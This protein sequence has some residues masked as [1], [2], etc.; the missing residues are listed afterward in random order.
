MQVGDQVVAIGN[1]LNLGDT[2]TVTTGIV[3][4]KGRTHR[5]RTE[6][7][8]DLIQTD[9]AINPGNSGGP[10]LNAPA[11]VV[12]INTAGIPDAENI[13]FAIS[14]DA[15]KPAHRRAEDR[16]GRRSRSRRSSGSAAPTPSSSPPTRPTAGRER[17]GRRGRRRRAAAVGRLRRRARGRRHPRAVDGKDVSGSADAP[18]AIQG[19]Q[20]GSTI[21]IEVDRAGQAEDPLRRPRLAGRYRRL[22]PRRL[23]GSRLGRPYTAAPPAGGSISRP[24]RPEVRMSIANPA[25]EPPVGHARVIYLGPVSP[26]WEIGSD[27]GDRNVVEEFKA[28]ALARLVLLPA[29]S[30]VPP[31]PGAHRARHRARAHPARLGSAAR[32]RGHQPG[33]LRGSAVSG[34]PPAGL[35]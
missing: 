32:R 31:Q 26:H 33:G 35:R 20:P 5:G 19:H 12:G 30:A 4:A 27:F 13:G 34:P 18:D 29:R 8:D 22:A 23:H 2:P 25:T 7:A 15:I 11:Q 10:L 14:I 1:A 21:S 6:D 16:Q 24:N 3:S 28:R 9:A 17:Q